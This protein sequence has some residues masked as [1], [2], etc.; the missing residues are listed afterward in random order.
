MNNMDLQQLQTEL[1]TIGIVNG[2]EEVNNE[3][4]ISVVE[5]L[6]PI[7]ATSDFINIANNLIIQHY[8]TMITFVNEGGSIKSIF[9]S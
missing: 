3:L 9:T 2:L 7:T 5:F 1:E 4:R 8:P 6:N